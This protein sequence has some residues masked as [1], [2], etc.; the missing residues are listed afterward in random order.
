MGKVNVVSLFFDL[1]RPLHDSFS[2]AVVLLNRSSSSA[3]VTAHWTDLGITGDALVRDLWTK[4]DIGIF[5]EC[6]TATVASHGVV[7]LR[8]SQSPVFSWKIQ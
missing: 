5:T 8:I 7:M 1:L 2:V 6:Y 4:Q 3:R